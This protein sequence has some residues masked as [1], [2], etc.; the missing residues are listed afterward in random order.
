MKLLYALNKK[1]NRYYVVD[2]DTRKLYELSKLSL[3]DMHKE[4]PIYNINIYDGEIKGK[5]VSLGR[6]NDR[7]MDGRVYVYRVRTKSGSI[8]CYDLTTS[9]GNLVSIKVSDIHKV[10]QMYGIINISPKSLDVGGI[11]LI[12]GTYE[13]VD[14]TSKTLNYVYDIEDYL[15]L[16]NAYERYGFSQDKQVTDTYRPVFGVSFTLEDSRVESNIDSFIK[17][18]KL[19][20]TLLNRAKEIDYAIPVCN[21]VILWKE[22][23]TLKFSA[24]DLLGYLIHFRILINDIEYSRDVIVDKVDKKIM[25]LITKSKVQTLKFSNFQSMVSYK[26]EIESDI[27]GIVTIKEFNDTER[28][29]DSFQKFKSK[30]IKVGRVE[31][32]LVNGVYKDDSDLRLTIRNN[33]KL[34]AAENMRLINRLLGK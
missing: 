10:S 26:G 33:L 16:F 9:F 4:T 3:I 13:T 23:N 8:F 7:R 29:E 12:D 32:H 21:K 31:L 25:S 22:N 15:M 1:L 14:E 27:D 24:Q 30:A 19:L 2:T 6:F 20:V 17:N 11:V 34:N 5:S 28:F 18:H